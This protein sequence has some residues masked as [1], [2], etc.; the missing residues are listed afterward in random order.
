MILDTGHYTK[1]LYN[2]SFTIQLFLSYFDVVWHITIHYN[3][4]NYIHDDPEDKVHNDGVPKN[5]NVSGIF[6]SD[7]SEA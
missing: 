5:S 6:W 2:F 4:T 1:Y 7:A 3:P